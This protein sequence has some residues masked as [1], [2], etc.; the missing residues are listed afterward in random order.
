ME[1]KFKGLVAIN[2]VLDDRYQ[3]LCDRYDSLKLSHNRKKR[4]LE[5][6]LE[7]VNNELG[8][9][10][11]KSD[12]DAIVVFIGVL[13]LMKKRIESALWSDGRERSYSCRKKK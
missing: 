10:S 7:F 12:Y 8:L 11:E 3:K 1:K 6:I 2:D 5:K 13:R 9:V 4:E